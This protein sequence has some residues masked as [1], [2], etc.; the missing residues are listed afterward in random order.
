MGF[1]WSGVQIPPARPIRTPT[2]TTTSR[3]LPH[4][5]NPPKQATRLVLRLVTFRSRLKSDRLR[6]SLI[7]SPTR[8]RGCSR[9]ISM[10]EFVARHVLAAELGVQTQTI[11][12]WERNGWFPEPEQ[13]IS[14]RLILY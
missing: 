7:A 9:R 4:P 2:P 1:R 5:T 14:D 12:K 8:L 11:A 10:N 3:R 13:R 6:P